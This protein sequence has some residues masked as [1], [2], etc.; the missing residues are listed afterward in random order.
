MTSIKGTPQQAARITY[1]EF[2]ANLPALVASMSSEFWGVFLL[3]CYLGAEAVFLFVCS[4]TGKSL[5]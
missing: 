4:A 3:R 1:M 2:K 5:I